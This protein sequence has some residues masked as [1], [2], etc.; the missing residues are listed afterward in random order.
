MEAPIDI[1]QPIAAPAA[2]P[3]AIVAPPAAAPVMED[4]GA[5]SSILKPKMNIKDIVISALLVVV[6]IYGIVYYRR[7]LKAL[8]ENPSADEFDTLRG[9]VDEVMYN[10]KKKLG[11]SY[12]MT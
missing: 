11:K 4:G 9:D 5:M 6:T 1:N 2:A 8:E 10:L 3:A 7:G 12:E